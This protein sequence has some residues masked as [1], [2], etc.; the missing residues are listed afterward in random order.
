MG[1]GDAGIRGF[2]PWGGGAGPMERA[3][4]PGLCYGRAP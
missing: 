1:L 2:P 4:P 3:P